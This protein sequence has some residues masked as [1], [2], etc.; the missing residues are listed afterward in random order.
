MDSKLAVAAAPGLLALALQLITWFVL[1]LRRR[2]A[3][4]RIEKMK[5]EIR[6]EVE[7]NLK[8]QE[9]R[10][11]VHGELQLRAQD[12]SWALLRDIMVGAVDAHQCVLDLAFASWSNDP[13]DRERKYERA[14]AAMIKLQALAAVAPPE[15][16]MGP[17]MAAL[18]RGHRATL[19]IALDG[20][21][22]EPK[23]HADRMVAIR[24][25]LD[26][27]VASASS[28]CKRWNAKL[29]RA[30]MQLTGGSVASASPSAG[31][32]PPP[33]GSLPPPAGPQPPAADEKAS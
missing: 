25:D 10:L 26:A 2:R 21:S 27:G 6:R 17:M 32:L 22:L 28:V 8:A 19:D 5:G 23:K 12:R 16:D 29:W 1:W 14:N 3:A 31:S 7:E 30:S 33:A 20:N 9:G 18:R 24:A 11:R 4:E 15:E 13:E